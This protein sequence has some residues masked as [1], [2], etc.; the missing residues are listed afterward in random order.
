VAEPWRRAATD[1][2]GGEDVTAALTPCAAG[3]ALVPGPCV[4]PALVAR[5][6]EWAASSIAATASGRGTPSG[7]DM[8]SGCA[9]RRSAP[10]RSRAAAAMLAL[11]AR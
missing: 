8:F 7:D 3:I 11:R 1:L 2:F 10:A 6:P 5:N 4:F 9:A